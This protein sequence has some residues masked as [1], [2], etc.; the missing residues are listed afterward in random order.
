MKEKFDIDIDYA[1]QLYNSGISMRKIADILECS[2]TK[3]QKELSSY[4]FNKNN[5]YKLVDGKYLIA[6]CKKT[7]KEFKD[8]ENK[9][10]SITEHLLEINPNIEIPSHYKRKDILYKTFK[11]WYDGYFDFEYRDL[12][13]IVE[14]VICGHEFKDIDNK[15]GAYMKHMIN[16]HNIDIDEHLK[17][18]P[19]D[20]I[21][22]KSYKK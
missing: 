16:K 8:H 12:D 13:N 6:I 2:F 1:I 19:Q 9:N 3:I 15:S 17:K 10:G 11:Y 7:K 14:C 4:E 22:F 18:Y 5:P 20:E 21:F